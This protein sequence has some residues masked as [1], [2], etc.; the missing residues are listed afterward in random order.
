MVWTQEFKA[1]QPFVITAAGQSGDVTMVKILAQKAKLT[2]NFDKL[3]KP[4]KLNNNSTLVFVTG[5]STKGL[6]AAKIDKNQELTRV[7]DLIK[8]AQKSEMKIITMHLGGK[9]RRGKLS[10]EFN[11]ITAKN[12]DCLIV[13]KGGDED[14]LFSNIAKEKKIPIF[15]IPKIIDAGIVM[16]NIFSK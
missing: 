9:S 14:K 11:K 3:A 10:D 7:Q 13:V 1:D 4:E 16:K 5:G 15:T 6:G 2:F 12:S 8:T